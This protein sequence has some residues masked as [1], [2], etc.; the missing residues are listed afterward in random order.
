MVN[1][2]ETGDLGGLWLKGVGLS[3]GPEAMHRFS[4]VRRAAPRLRMQPVELLAASFGLATKTA[5]LL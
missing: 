5:T 3:A 2:S 4:R 1:R